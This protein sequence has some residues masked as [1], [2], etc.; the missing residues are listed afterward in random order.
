[1]KGKEKPTRTLVVPKQAPGQR[2]DADNVCLGSCPTEGRLAGIQKY[3]WPGVENQE[4]R[5]GWWSTGTMRKREGSISGTLFIKGNKE[6]IHLS[7]RS[8]KHVST[9]SSLVFQMPVRNL[10][11]STTYRCHTYVNFLVTPFHPFGISMQQAYLALLMFIF[12]HSNSLSLEA[13]EWS[14]PFFSPPKVGF[15]HDVNS[16]FLAIIYFRTTFSVKEG[17]HCSEE[18]MCRINVAP[19]TISPQTISLSK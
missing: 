14:F 9:F 6:H 1:M 18:R 5:G 7:K 4:G 19:S 12:L 13:G 17:Y 10:S 3:V 15:R 11:K 16:L 2:Q 8:K